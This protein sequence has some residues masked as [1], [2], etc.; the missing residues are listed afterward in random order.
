MDTAAYSAEVT[1]ADFD[2]LVIEQSRRLPVVA[3]FWAAWCGPCQMLMPILAKLAREYAGRFFLAK[4]NTDEER[5]LAARHGIRGLPTVKIFRDGQVV[6]EFMGALPESEIRRIL[7]RH[8]PRPSDPLLARAGERR[9]AGDLAGARAALEEA[10]ALDPGREEIRFELAE[11]LLALGALEAARETL[12]GL[13]APQQAEPRARAL[14]TRLDFARL[15]AD[16]PDEAALRRRLE[17]DP[18]DLTARHQLAARAVAA[19]DYETAME[20]LL[21]IV[22]R[23]RE[24]NEEAGRKG[25]V[26]LFELVGSDHPLVKTY[27]GKLAMVLN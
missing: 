18:G 22:R 3:D 12:A 16:A 23:D 14:A 6:D 24:W 4:I 9:Q 20:A 7:D 25:L 19:G 17:A 10:L 5:D 26:A 21:E 2:A 11:V 13:S 15:A 8:L 27:R 1:G